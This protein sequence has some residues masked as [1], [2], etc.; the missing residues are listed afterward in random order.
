METL[1]VFLLLAALIFLVW[2]RA[3]KGSDRNM[4]MAMVWFLLS[5]F[6]IIWCL[7][8]PMRNYTAAC[9]LVW[10]P[11]LFMVLNLFQAIRLRKRNRRKKRKL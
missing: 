11:G 8:E 10:I 6:W 5:C 4:A 3:M 1:S 2:S 9:Y 7:L